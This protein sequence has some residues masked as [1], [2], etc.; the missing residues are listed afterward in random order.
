MTKCILRRTHRTADVR[1]LL[2]KLQQQETSQQSVPMTA[3]P[4]E[5]SLC[6]HTQDHSGDKG[7]DMGWNDCEAK[8]ADTHL[9]TPSTGT[10]EKL[11]LGSEGSEAAGLGTRTARVTEHSPLT[12]VPHQPKPHFK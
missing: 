5:K 11:S 8:G 3:S 12:L 10:L 6:S 9:V 1:N 2:R 7:Q 4:A